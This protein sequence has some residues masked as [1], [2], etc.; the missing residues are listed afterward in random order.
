MLHPYLAEFPPHKLC[1]TFQRDV[2]AELEL[3]I[4]AYKI[5]QDTWYTHWTSPGNLPILLHY[6]GRLNNAFLKRHPHADL[7][8]LASFTSH[9]IT[10][11]GHIHPDHLPGAAHKYTADLMCFECVHRLYGVL[12]PEDD[13]VNTSPRT[14]LKGGGGG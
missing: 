10:V 9:C 5:D 4:E 13:H 2:T 6:V 8:D 12:T 11:L 3:V 14:P 7:D 1:P